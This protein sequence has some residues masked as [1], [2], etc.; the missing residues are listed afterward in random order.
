MFICLFVLKDR[1]HR[2][3]RRKELRCAQFAGYCSLLSNL[4]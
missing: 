1:T 2:S 4:G 3:G